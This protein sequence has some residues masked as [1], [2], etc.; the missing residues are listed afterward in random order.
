MSAR[1]FI[2]EDNP[3]IQNLLCKLLNKMP[4]FHVCGT[5]STAK[6][7]LA[8][9]STIEVDLLLIDI[10][11]PGISGIDFVS[12]LQSQQP[13]L[14]C[15]MLSGYQEP[16]YVKDALAA[17]ARGYV[18]KGAFYELAG[19][20]RQVLAGEIYLSKQVRMLCCP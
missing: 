9:L 13:Q 15:L 4:N 12:M 8:L 16:V 6:E 11:L 17:G 20:I 3:M 2:V 19:A 14:R 5:A 10:S 1:I 7:A 18:V